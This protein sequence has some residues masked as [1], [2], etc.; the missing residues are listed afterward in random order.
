MQTFDIVI[1][2][3]RNVKIT[4]YLN[5][6]SWEFG[7]EK[8]PLMIVLPGGGYAFHSDREAEVIALQYMAAGYQAG[9]LYY[10]LRDKGG[11]PLPLEDYDTAVE[12]IG[13]HADEW[14]I[15]MSR[16]ATVGFSAGGHL[17]ACTATMAKHKPK[18]S[19]CVYPAILPEIL[20]VCEPGLPVPIDYVDD[21]TSP[22]LIVGARD[23]MLV[24]AKNLLRFALALEEQ[25]IS[26]ECHIY[27]Y[28]GHGFSTGTT[29]MLS[30]DWISE[31]VQQWI[32]NSIT[33]LNEMMGTLTKNGFTKPV[34]NPHINGDADEY[35]S[36]RCSANYLYR[37]SE[38]VQE[39]MKPFYDR[40]RRIADE[41]GS[42]FEDMLK[43][44][45][46][47]RVTDI[48]LAF[49]FSGKEVGAIDEKLQAIPNKR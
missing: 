46:R 23:D 10:T 17:A 35:L 45:G 28:G 42:T 44:T 21:K 36:V 39:V 2:E 22:C 18:A 4:M 6:E 8:R 11:W 24:E 41:R 1:S 40:L 13:A 3:E 26:F 15:D 38:Q 37:Q 25:G 12:L 49:G 33:W 14:R 9:V 20:E 19:I 32:P 29:F 16:I 31:R 27:S 30:S 5:M 47:G 7:F 48:M 43:M 34:L